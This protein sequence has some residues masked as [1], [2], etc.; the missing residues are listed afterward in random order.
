MAI[1]KVAYWLDIADYDLETA[2]AMLIT[3]RWL[4]VGFMCH[5]VLEKT[6]KAYWCA[7]QPEDPPYTHNLL[8][9]AQGSKLSE[10]LSIEQKTF[11]QSMMPLNI[12]ARYPEY[13]ETLMAQLTPDYC[14]F[15]YDNTKEMQ[16]WIKE[17]LSK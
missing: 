2:N 5:Q 11:I 15:I 8:N 10:N 16:Q 6:L 12:E 4:Y 14:Q 7:T 9:L 1:D 3:R 13:K 17:K